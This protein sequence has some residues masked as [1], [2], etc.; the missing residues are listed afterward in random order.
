MFN[1]TWTTISETGELEELNPSEPT[2]S[3]DRMRDLEKYTDYE[4]STKDKLAALTNEI[5]QEANKTFES[6][7]SSL[8]IG[9]TTVKFLAVGT[10][11]YLTFTAYKKVTHGRS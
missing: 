6:I 1:S 11:A 9:A 2:L 7:G 8:K 10:A 5:S 4:F 3:Y